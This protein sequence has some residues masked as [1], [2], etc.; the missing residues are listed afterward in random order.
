MIT[1]ISPCIP[2]SRPHRITG[3][4]CRINTVVSPDDGHTVARN[5]YRKEINILKKIVHQIDFIYKTD[6]A[7]TSTYTEHIRIN[8]VIISVISDF[9]REEDEN[10]SLLGYHAVSSGIY[11]CSLRD[12]PGQR[13]SLNICLIERKCF[14]LLLIVCLNQEIYIKGP[15]HNE[16]FSCHS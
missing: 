6:E 13:N 10:C 4:K 7:W 9:R 2:D 11:H 5:L 12:S 3:T 16:N 14:V 1:F 8:P 15:S